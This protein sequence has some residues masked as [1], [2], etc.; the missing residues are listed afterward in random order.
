MCFSVLTYECCR[1]PASGVNHAPATVQQQPSAQQPQQQPVSL[2]TD[3]NN[4]IEHLQQLLL[5]SSKEKEKLARENESLKR[6][7]E[8]LRRSQQQPLPSSNQQPSQSQQQQQS[9]LMKK[10]SIDSPSSYQQSEKTSLV[11]PEATNTPAN[12]NQQDK[13]L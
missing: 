10:P 13:A 1:A 12:T 3:I 4:T 6:E 2:S 5:L 8:R 11:A 7:V 9:I